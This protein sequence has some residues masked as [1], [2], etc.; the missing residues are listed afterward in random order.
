[1]NEY[2]AENRRILHFDL[3]RL[4]SW[5]ELEVIGFESFLA[6]ADISFIEWPEIALPYLE[7]FV[8]CSID[9]CRYGN[10]VS[11]KCSVNV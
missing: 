7:N 8:H 9:F 6:E 5:E 4:D 2:F 10:H 3:Y 11:I 1:M